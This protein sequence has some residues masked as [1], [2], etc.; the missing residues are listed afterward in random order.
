[1]S[2]FVILAFCMLAIDFTLVLLF[3][4]AYGEKRQKFSRERLLQEIRR[5]TR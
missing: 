1:V 2:P 5:A 4:L 3:H